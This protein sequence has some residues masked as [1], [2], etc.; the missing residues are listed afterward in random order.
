MPFF[1][2]NVPPMPEMKREERVFDCLTDGRKTHSDG[3]V[4]P[5]ADS[6]SFLLKDGGIFPFRRVETAFAGILPSVSN[7]RKIVFLHDSTDKLL[8]A[9]DALKLC[10]LKT[11]GNVLTLKEGKLTDVVATQANYGDEF[12][13]LIASDAGTYVYRKQG[14]YSKVLGAPS[15]QA[16][17]YCYGR[18]FLLSAAENKVYISI[19]DTPYAWDLSGGNGGY[20]A[21]QPFEGVISDMVAFDGKIYLLRGDKVSVIRMSGKMVDLKVETIAADV[22]NVIR[23]T[24]QCI[25]G[26]IVFARKDGLFTFNGQKTEKAALRTDAEREL[27]TGTDFESAVYDGYYILAYTY[28]TARRTLFYD[29]KTGASCFWTDGLFSPTVAGDKLYFLYGG[30]VCTFAAG[31]SG[32]EWTSVAEDF[33]RA[34]QRKCLRRVERS[35]EGMVTV[36]VYADGKKKLERSMTGN[37]GADCDIVGERFVVKI[38]SSGGGSVTGLRLAADCPRRG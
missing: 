32:G 20:I 24:T 30:K 37:D 26:K 1:R 15:G 10:E 21:F 16:L 9:G 12:A 19:T 8:M 7:L 29:F 4:L 6:H 28:G 14:G 33:G 11:G 13:A 31:E 27:A 34:G 18:F 35:G 3:S 36:A 38:S 22:G 17:A 25:S 2:K 5:F 23:G